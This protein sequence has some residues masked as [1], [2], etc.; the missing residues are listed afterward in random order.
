MSSPSHDEIEKVKNNIN[1]II[2]FNKD[3]LNQAN[4]KL[5]NAFVLLSQSDNQDLG[6]QIGINLMG[7][8]FWALGSLLGPLG[9]IPANLLSGLVSNYATSTPP[10]L[11]SIFSSIITRLQSTINQVNEDLAVYYQDPV[12]NWDKTFGGSFKTP[13]G[14]YNANGKIGDLASM[15]FPDQTDPK[16]YDILKGCVLALDQ[17]MWQLLLQ[18]FVVTHYIESRPVLWNLPCDP[19]QEDNNF[20]PRNKSYFNT[21]EY[22]EDKDCYGNLVKYYDREQYNLGTGA[23]TWSDG[24]LN[25]SACNYLFINYASDVANPDG[26]FE[27]V[28]VFTNLGI[29]T[30][31]KYLN[32]GAT[33]EKKQYDENIS[34]K[35]KFLN[36]FN[37]CNCRRTYKKTILTSNKKIKH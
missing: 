13:F 10:S 35:N 2:S 24:A 21:W 11:N 31:N 16:Y 14:S 20:L 12:L 27:R 5:E 17:T 1:K 23:G 6:L 29:P 3:V 4:M 19:N 7:G 25:D 26:L 15:D 22:H 9:S 8:C 30:A 32:N 34:L 18:R 33:S 28:F 36:V 37:F